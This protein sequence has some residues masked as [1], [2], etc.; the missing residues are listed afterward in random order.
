[1]IAPVDA[2]VLAVDQLIN[3]TYSG[4]YTDSVT[5]VDG[6]HEGEPF[7]EGGAARPT[8][9]FVDNSAVY[10]DLNADAVEDAAVLLVES[11]GGSGVFTYVGTQLNQ[12]GR[13]VDAG[14]V[15]VGDRTQ[16]KSMTI[17]NGQVVLELVTQGP[18]DPQCCPTLKVRKTYALQDG[19]LAE[20][21]S[22]ALGA[23]SLD[24]LMGTSWVLVDFNFDQQPVLPDTQITATFADSKIS[25]SDGCNNYNAG[26]TSQSGQTLTIGLGISTQMACPDSIM[27]QATQY[28]A[29]LQGVDQWSYLVGQLALT[30]QTADGSLGTLL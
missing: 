12:N 24:D 28:L 18:D 21:G 11:S 3:A 13:P 2:G 25:G 17:E 14:A 16:V 8:V 26:L 7:V 20:V 29:A 5:L 19:K 27:A 1:M 6:L 30:Y 22:E 9:Q 15:W 23:V 10:G 4:I